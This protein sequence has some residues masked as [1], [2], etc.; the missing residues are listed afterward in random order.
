MSTAA[1]IGSLP[2]TPCDFDP[3][4]LAD[5]PYDPSV[6]MFDRILEIDR[7]Q[8]RVVCRMPTDQPIPFT[9]QQRAHP[10]R[11]PRHVAGAALIHATGMLGFV[12]AYH[13]LGVRHSGGWI[14]YGTHI[15]KA[16]QARAAGADRS[17]LQGDS[18]AARRERHVVR[19]ARLPPR[20]RALLRVIRARSDA[21]QGLSRRSAER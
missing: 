4:F 9:Q 20:G 15:H 5:L 7:E 16:A 6:L 2:E 10:D 14:G 21:H 1:T 12:H 8:S 11:H 18:A 19:Y 13:L 17:G 3:E